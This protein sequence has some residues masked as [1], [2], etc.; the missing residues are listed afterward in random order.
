MR[1]LCLQCLAEERQAKDKGEEEAEAREAVTLAP[2]WA[3]NAF[4]GQMVMACVAV[5]SCRE[6]LNI[7]DKTPQ[8]RAM[9]GGIVLGK[10]GGS[11]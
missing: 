10:D 11:R 4:M 5:P 9:E 6:H 7:Q 2:T 8:Q 3:S 1:L